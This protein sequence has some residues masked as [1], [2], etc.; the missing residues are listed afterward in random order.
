MQEE[1]LDPVT[2]TEKSMQQ[3][4]GALIGITTVL[5]AVFVPMAFF[6]GTTGVIYR[7]FSITLVTAM[8]LSLAIAL[9]FTPALCAT[10]LKQHDKDK[11]ESNGVF[12]RFFRWFNHGFGPLIS[13]LP[14][15]GR[16][17]AD[18]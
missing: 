12:A 9:T 2:A 1:H 3:I 4:S 8:I 5:T 7:Q 15:M 17:T 10:L 16:Q 13:R 14:E 11:P 18:S 6:S